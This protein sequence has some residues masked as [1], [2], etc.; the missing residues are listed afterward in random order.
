M[1]EEQKKELSEQA[2]PIDEVAAEGDESYEARME[3][4]VGSAPLHRPPSYR[5]R[6][7]RGNTAAESEKEVDRQLSQ[8]RA[9][10]EKRIKRGRITLIVFALLS[11]VEVVLQFFNLWR[12]PLSC[13]LS[14]LLSVYGLFSVP[15]L[16]AA[17]LPIIYMIVLAIGFRSERMAFLRKCLPIFLWVDLILTLALGGQPYGL[18]GYLVKEMVFNLLLHIPVIWFMQR[19]VRAVDALEILPTKE[20]E[21]DPFEGLGYNEYDEDGGSESSAE[22]DDRT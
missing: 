20:M 14:D 21:G 13:T 6:S 8:R 22:E 10:M 5:T 3:R 4:L 18:E 11:L 15:C 1:N 2:K 7:F 17:F 9:L 12:L 16:I 19:A